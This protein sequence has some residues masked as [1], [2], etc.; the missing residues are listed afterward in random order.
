MVIKRIR[1]YVT[2]CIKFFS[3]RWGSQSK[4]R[5]TAKRVTSMALPV[6]L[7]LRAWWRWHIDPWIASRAVELDGRKQRSQRE[8]KSDSDHFSIVRLRTH[9]PE[10]LSLL[11]VVKCQFEHFCYF[12]TLLHAA[13]FLA[14]DLLFCKAS[15]HWKPNWR[16]W[17]EHSPTRR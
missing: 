15:C 8:A 10:C 1:H 11:R 14:Q 17:V 6:T 16:G 4:P 13:L 2:P 3:R 5:H 12:A 9:S 7:R